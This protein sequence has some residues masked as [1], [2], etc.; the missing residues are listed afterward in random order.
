LK[1]FSRPARSLLAPTRIIALEAACWAMLVAGLSLDILWR[2]AFW[3]VWALPIIALHVVG[4][5]EQSLESGQA[6]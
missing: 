1:E 3:F 5:N 2:K 4:K 6:E